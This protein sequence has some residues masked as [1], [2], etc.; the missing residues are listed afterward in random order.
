[1]CRVLQQEGVED[2]GQGEDRS[3]L[4]ALSFASQAHS[5]QE[6]VPEERG[7]ALTNDKQGRG[8]LGS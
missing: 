6:I 3:V 2:R 7:E 5:S 8:V 1:M 4:L